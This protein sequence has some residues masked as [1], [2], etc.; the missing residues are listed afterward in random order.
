M[1]TVTLR[2]IRL[3]ASSGEDLTPTV[4]FASALPKL[5]RAT[6]VLAVLL[7]PLAEGSTI[8]LV[9]GANVNMV[10]GTTWPD[11]DPFLQRQN[12]PSIAVSSRNPLHLMAGAN[13]YRSVDI[14][15]VLGADELG[16]VW[17]GVF[18][19]TDG[20]TTWKSTLLPGCPYSIPQ[21]DVNPASPLKG[22]QAAADPT[23]RAGTNGLFYLSG[24]AFNRGTNARGVVFLTR[25]IDNDN[26]ENGNP[27]TYLGTNLIDT[28]TAGQFLDKPWVA[29]DIPRSGAGKCTVFTGTPQEQSFGAGNVY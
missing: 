1:R 12:E 3:R 28:G 13:D 23:V 2:M 20:G 7:A 9:P 21:C 6:I 4:R 29:A 5:F 19:S 22:L 11:G 15:G 18:R 16:D 14:P 8:Q 17:M 24:I 26:K 25:Y 10:A 27:F